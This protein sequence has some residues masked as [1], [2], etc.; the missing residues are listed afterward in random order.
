MWCCGAVLSRLLSTVRTGLYFFPRA[1]VRAAVRC[2]VARPDRGRPRAPSRSRSR[3]ERRERPQRTLGRAGRGR[4]VNNQGQAV[5][6]PPNSA[7]KCVGGGL[8]LAPTGGGREAVGGQSREGFRGEEGPLSRANR[9]PDWFQPVVRRHRSASALGALRRALQADAC[10]ENGGRLAGPVVYT[11]QPLRAPPRRR[12]HPPSDPE[13][14]CQLRPQQH[15]PG[16]C[17]HAW[18][19]IVVPALAQ[20]HVLVEHQE[21]GDAPN[22]GVMTLDDVL[23]VLRSDAIDWA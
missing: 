5:T 9:G 7:H 3:D 23:R 12:G 21:P 2:S 19:H 20:H 16:A 4:Q 22:D 6:R 11:I 15:W 14:A 18:P 10:A 8:E 17:P 1:D 13:L